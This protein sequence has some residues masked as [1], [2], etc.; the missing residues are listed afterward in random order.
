MGAE[1]N[2]KG[3][4]P[5]AESSDRHETILAEA[6]PEGGVDAAAA[7]EMHRKIARRLL[8]EGSPSRA[9]A[10]LVR[11]AREAPLTPR[12]AA[13]IVWLSE[14]VG[15]EASAVALLRTGIEDNDGGPRRQIRSQL[16]RLLRRVGEYDKAREQLTV[17]LAENPAD[18]RARRVLNGL[19]HREQRWEELDASLERE[20]KEALR[21]NRLARAARSTFWR[22]RIA[23]EGLSSPAHAALRY[24]QAAQLLEQARDY[25]RAFDVRL[26][27]LRALHRAK[28][29]RRAVEE[30]LAQLRIAAERVGKVRRAEALMTEL[31][32]SPPKPA[33]G[34][35]HGRKITS[36]ELIA[37]AEDADRRGKRVEAAAMLSAV[38]KDTSDVSARTRLEAL[39][40]SRGAWRELAQFYRMRAKDTDDRQ[41]RVE[42]LSRLAEV[43]EDELKDLRAAEEV[44]GEMVG[45]GDDDHA[46]QEQLRLLKSRE[47]RSGIRRAL[48]K[49]VDGASDS[50]TMAGALVARGEAAATGKDFEKAKRDFAQALKLSPNHLPA[51]AG[52]A[53]LAAQQGEHGP[54][55]TFQ[56]ALEKLPRRQSGR[57]EL[58][59]RLARLADNPLDEPNTAVRAWSEVLAE[60]PTDDEATGR[61]SELLRNSGDVARLEP[62]LRARLN[63]EPRGAQARESWREL[64]LALEKLGRAEDALG[65]LRQAVRM[66]PGHLE[67]WL[68][69]ADR[70][71][72]RGL[73]AEAAWAME[74]AATSTTDDDQRE[75][76][77]T[78]L[79][80]YTREVLKDPKV[81]EQH[82][83]RAEKLKADRDARRAKTSGLP[84]VFVPM[85]KHPDSAKARVSFTEADRT[86]GRMPPSAAP[87]PVKFS[88]TAPPP[89]VRPGVARGEDDWAHDDKTLRRDTDEAL[90]G[91]VESWDPNADILEVTSGEIEPPSSEFKVPDEAEW[92]APPGRMD[93]KDKN[94]P[95]DEERPST[96][97]LAV[98]LGE[99]DLRLEP[100]WSSPE[101]NARRQELFRI[102]RQTPLQSAGYH[103]LSAYFD[104]IGDTDRSA[105]M[106]EIANALEG[107]PD[108]AP[109]T[110]RL[111]LNATD[112]AG[113]RHPTLRHEVGELLSL[114]GVALCR[115]FP[116]K[117]PTSARDEF[118]LDSGKGAPLTAEALLAA[119]RILG[120]RA[121]DLFLSDQNGPPFSVV[122]GKDG[123]R[124]A[125]GRLAVKKELPEA[126]LRFFA[127]RALFTQNPDLLA[128][129]LLKREQL[130][131]GL[132]LLGG[133]LKGSRSLTAEGRSMRDALS[134]KGMERLRFLFDRHVRTLSLPQLMDGARHSVNRAGIVVSGSVAPAL[135]ALNAK[136]ALQAEVE[137]LIR[138][139]ASERYLQFRLRRIGAK[140]A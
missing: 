133:V 46:L 36:V 51:L 109:R 34:D 117:L 132:M 137:E 25:E 12:L 45:L 60:L 140:K 107:D 6:F 8:E 138:F 43:L 102:V 75:K 112:R 27:W 39:Y 4:P 13:A 84:G 58:Y 69:L 85:P 119:V 116:E 14:R 15:T 135:H 125:I 134:P 49:A 100:S 120:L 113:L 22:G 16:V 123:P 65:Q 11:A 98:P 70:A 61:L 33:R 127:G 96:Q 19:L 5:R 7:A 57:A 23:D 17:L 63:K 83:Q 35:A 93:W 99:E 47:D 114:C 103:D 9:Y 128:L 118:R 77:W 68:L 76:L 52:L 26:L 29:P 92:E 32:L 115:L 88:S 111:I 87:T 136:K 40:V 95:F 54:A 31:G 110:P 21:D 67:A 20:A 80:R 64:V 41:E 24:G 74:H 90:P 2:G 129:R 97:E 48:D 81:A 73:V 131:R 44:Y 10:E 122:F 104:E 130:Q 18:R 89:A 66:E 108:A 53:E 55:T 50:A 59:R 126:E 86:P 38:V 121:P 62:V 91:P 82:R 94:K 78:R 42:L 56:T 37:A 105:L 72:K 30:A 71:E 28:Q 79:G 124:L 1:R 106:T 101:G 139:S 3:R